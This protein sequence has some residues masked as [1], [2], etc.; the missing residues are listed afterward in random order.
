MIIP[1]EDKTADLLVTH[2]REVNFQQSFTPQSKVLKVLGNQLIT[3]SFSSSL[4]NK[5]ENIEYSDQT[6]VAKVNYIIRLLLLFPLECY[7]KRERN[8]LLWLLLL[9]DAWI[10]TSVDSNSYSVLCG[11]LQCRVLYLRFM[12]A[13]SNAGVL[14]MDYLF[15]F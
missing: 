13:I 2:I 5:S 3:S 14:V 8:Q 1:V 7:S 12:K 11:S 6:F 15:I 4:M 9:I 10:L